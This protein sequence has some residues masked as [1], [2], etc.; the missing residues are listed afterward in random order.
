MATFTTDEILADI[1]SPQQSL[2]RLQELEATGRA[3]LGE[4]GIGDWCCSCDEQILLG[5]LFEYRAEDP[6]ERTD[7]PG[8]L[9]ADCAI[10]GADR[11][12]AR[13][14]ELLAKAEYRCELLCRVVDRHR[15]LPA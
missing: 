1:Q 9:C 11:E 6:S 7:G 10:A 3:A 2:S 14:A 5:D 12:H 13:L 4:R 15:D 8:L